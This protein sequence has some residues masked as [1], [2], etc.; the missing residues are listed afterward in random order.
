VGGKNARRKHIRVIEFMTAVSSLQRVERECAAQE[1]HATGNHERAAEK[2]QNT[3]R[4]GR[5]FWPMGQ[6]PSKKESESSGKKSLGIG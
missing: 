2:V 3:Q 1:I 5:S 6:N 4:A